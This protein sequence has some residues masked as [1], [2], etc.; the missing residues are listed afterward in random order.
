LEISGG[1]HRNY[2]SLTLVQFEAKRELLDLC[3]SGQ[4][5]GMQ[6]PTFDKRVDG[7]QPTKDNS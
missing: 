2:L 1:V 6:L 7:G 5:C 4:G 3:R